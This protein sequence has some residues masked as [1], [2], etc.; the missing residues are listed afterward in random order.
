PELRAILARLAP[1]TRLLVI[2]PATA[3]F[4]PDIVISISA[5]AELTAYHALQAGTEIA[6]LISRI[7]AKTRHDEAAILAARSRGESLTEEI[8]PELTDETA[9]DADSPPV[10]LALQRAVQIHRAWLILGSK[11]P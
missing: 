4:A 2:G 7:T 5:E 1:H 8:E 11:Q 10:D 9:P 3:S 6:S